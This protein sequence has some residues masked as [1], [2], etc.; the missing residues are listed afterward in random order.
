[1]RSCVV[2]MALLV[3]AC[4]FHPAGDGGG[5]GGDD[6]GDASPGDPDATSNDPDA[7]SSDAP[8]DAAIDATRTDASDPGP[9]LC[10][11]GYAPINGSS[12][13]YRIVESNTTWALAAADCNDD[14]DLV[15]GITGRTHLVV[16]GDNTEKITL[17][18]QFS[19]NTWVGLTDEDDEGVFEWVTN[20]PTN[21]FPQ[22]GMQPPWDTGDPD[23]GT[24]ENCV[25]FKN[26]FD[27]EDKACTDPNSYVCE[28]DRFA[29]D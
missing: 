25:R 20:E 27:F 17:T 28:C 13:Q 22:V 29:P 10:P 12:T 6:V 4:G 3:G 19:G 24:A 15:S 5:G 18:N 14:D 11:L 9:T 21:G 23:G 26:S 8:L 1:M 7:A 16:V 2:A